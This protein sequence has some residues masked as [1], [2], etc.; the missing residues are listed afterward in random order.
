MGPCG[1]RHCRHAFRALDA[2]AADL[3]AS[4]GLAGAGD[5]APT[6]LGAGADGNNGGWGW[7]ESSAIAEGP[8]SNGP[9]GPD[10]R[11]QYGA[12][13]RSFDPYNRYA[14]EGYPYGQPPPPWRRPGDFGNFL[15]RALGGW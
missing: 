3:R 11:P 5:L 14:D 4:L 7:V 10:G 2:G 1:R 8:G 13:H 15:R 6:R 12:Y 9:G